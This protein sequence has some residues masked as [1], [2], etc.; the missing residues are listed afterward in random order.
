MYRQ[1]PV[2]GPKSSWE[3]NSQ[4]QGQTTRPPGTHN[5]LGQDEMRNIP[6]SCP[7]SVPAGYRVV[8]PQWQT[9]D[10][11]R[12][13]NQHLSFAVPTPSSDILP[14]GIMSFWQVVE[15]V[16]A[17]QDAINLAFPN[18]LP[19]PTISLARQSQGSH[20]TIVQTHEAPVFN[21]DLATA[22]LTCASFNGSVFR[23][24]TRSLVPTIATDGPAEITHHYGQWVPQAPPANYLA[25]GGEFVP[26]TPPPAE[27]YRQTQGSATTPSALTMSGGSNYG[28]IQGGTCDPRT[29]QGNTSPDSWI[30]RYP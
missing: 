25:L 12:L 2:S 13:V 7:A 28:S 9:E 27:S 17:Q 21:N 11:S 6:P 22:N 19:D 4:E 3:D 5:T 10:Q 26:R 29:Q 20:G 15:Y 16:T 30:S 14:P 18:T 8:P 24:A 23:S 1:L